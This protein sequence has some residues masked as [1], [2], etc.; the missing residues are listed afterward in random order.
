MPS[1]AARWCRGTSSSTTS[2]SSA[3]A[4]VCGNSRARPAST[5]RRSPRRW[6]RQWSSTSNCRRMAQ[7]H[8]T[9]IVEDGARL[10]SDV[11]V[12]A[13][14]L[15]GRDCV[16]GDGVTIAAH[17]TITGRTNIGPR[18]TVGVFSVIGSEPQDLSYRGEDTAVEVGPDCSIREHVTIH[19]GTAHGR[20][21]THVG[22]KCFLMIASHVAHDCLVSD[23]VI[24]TNQ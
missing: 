14:A 8:P 23:N 7:V 3:T 4:A 6:S 17:V 22:A 13:Y 15:V 12:G 5:A 18:T 16:I 21:I 20:G 19:R 24:L 1:S 10:G 2:R 11:S 9:A